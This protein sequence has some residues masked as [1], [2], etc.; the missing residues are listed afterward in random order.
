MQTF[1][2]TVTG[3]VWQFEDDVKATN[4]NGTYSF[5][6]ASG[7]ALSNVPATLQPYTIPTPTAAEKLAEEQNAKIQ[8][9]SNAAGAEV[10]A[11]FISNALGST[12]TYPSQQSDQIN[13]SG[14][15]TASQS[16][17]VSS[18]W[19]VKF[20]CADSSGNWALRDHSASQIQQVLTDGVTT[21]VGISEKLATLSAQIQGITIASGSDGSA[22]IAQVQAITW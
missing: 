2:D 6:T 9:L 15:V 16:P 18:T 8:A 10:V 19:G 17:N 7:D 14:A 1:K 5:E 11:G 4:S 13:L 20:W 21:R 12:Y 22:E 3:E